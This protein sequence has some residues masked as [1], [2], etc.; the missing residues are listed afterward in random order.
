M[1]RRAFVGGLC[2]APLAWARPARALPR[3][4]IVLASAPLATMQGEEPAETVM[5]GFLDGLRALGYAEGR[6]IVIE[7]RSA[8]GKFER[9]ETILRGLAQAPVDV[10]V[11]TGAPMVLAAKKVTSTV[12]IVA[13]GMGDP[14]ASGIVASLARPGGNI[15][16]VTPS[17]GPELG[18]KRLELIREML[19]EARRI[20]WLGLKQEWDYPAHKEMRSK[21]AAMGMSLTLL[22]ARLPGIEAT[23]VELERERPDA[24]YAPPSA[25][26]FV[27]TKA[28]AAAARRLG[29]PDFYGWSEGPEAGGL[30]SYGHS[31]SDLFRRAAGYVDRILKGAKPADLPIEQMDRYPLVLNLKTARALGLKVSQSLLLRAD[32]VIE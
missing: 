4:G 14:V 13:T 2:A 3:V 1:K 24:L 27:H 29:V 28:I 22:A 9:L 17:F 21:A 11:V 23:L 20:T 8:E 30:A 32:R 18:L 10:I 5:R 6:D 7:R 12:P 15:T 31:P 25:S 26:M 16:G 19:P